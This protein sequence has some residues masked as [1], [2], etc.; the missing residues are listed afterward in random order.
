MKRKKQSNACIKSLASLLFIISSIFTF[1]QQK[2]PI[3]YGKISA[4]DFNLPKST[5]IDSN[6]NAVIIAD[7]GNTSFVGNKKGW[8][9]YVFKRRKRI[10]IINKKAFDAATVKVMLYK[11][12]NAEEKLEGI[13]ASTYNLVN[14]SVIE[15]KLDKK[16]IFEDRHDK[17]HIE[18]KFTLPAVKEGSIIEYTYTITSDFYFNI[19]EWEFQNIDYPCLWSQ[20]EITIPNLL[21][22]VFLRQGIHPF[23]IDK[24]SEGRANYSIRDKREEGL[25]TTEQSYSVT[26]LTYSH[27]WVMKDVEAFNVE[28]FITTP[29]NYN[30]KIEF[31]LSQTYNGETTRD[32]KNNW[33]NATSELLQQSDFG[34]PLQQS[35]G[36]F[37]DIIKN[38]IGNETDDLEKAKKIYYYVRDNFTCN[39]FY[40]K[41]ILT[42]L[43]DVVKKRSGSVGE[44]NILLAT[45]LR[46]AKIHADPVLLSTTEFGFN[47]PSYPIMDRLNYVICRVKIWDKVYFLDAATPMLGFGKLAENCYNGHARIICDIDSGSVY[48]YADSIKEAKFTSV[49]IVN[50][51]KENGKMDGSF[52]STPG[53]F[54]STKIREKGEPDY[55]KNL[56]QQYDND[57][58][59]ENTSID[60]IKEYELPVKVRYDFSYKNRT[61]DDL[62][63]FS[64]V[65]YEG[66]MKNPFTAA[67]RKYPVE[68]NY[69]IDE[70]YILNADVPKG[71]TVDDIPKS[72]KITYNDTEGFF[73]YLIQQG[74]GRIMLRSHIKLNK[75]R[76]SAD[77][78]NS[79]RDFFAYVVKKQ[80]EQIVFKKKK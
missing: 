45:L 9:S 15:S 73:E 80:S 75:A 11:D 52:E 71:Y 3:I 43:H 65:I 10:K 55:F 53:Y 14:G 13:Q 79:L 77:D 20:Y 67:E 47:S 6:S 44:I 64:P 59:I 7:I 54:E 36:E 8:L 61:D 35:T 25:S 78:Y 46:N 21:I 16:D 19:P 17:N 30:D 42:T 49:F 69:P 74:D 12:E 41:Y 48:L 76:F 38:A 31:Q 34:A 39:N 27:T 56:R 63:Y 22:Y 4:T 37:D 70:T 50:D 2:E 51:E 5:A 62:I 18:N 60:S 24:S 68:M 72:V 29:Y 26:A 58:K 33:A 66:I 40:N 57:I 23:F 32:V 1:A 28:N